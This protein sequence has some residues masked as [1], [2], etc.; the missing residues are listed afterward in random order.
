MSVLH[1][2]MGKADPDRTRWSGQQRCLSSVPGISQTCSEAE[3]PSKSGCEDQIMDTGTSTLT[4]SNAGVAG[5]GRG[6]GQGADC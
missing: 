5:G 6:S 1:T 4:T 2:Q 3:L